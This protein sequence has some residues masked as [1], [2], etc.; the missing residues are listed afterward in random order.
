VSR[1]RDVACHA[2]THSSRL[3]ATSI[4]PINILRIPEITRGNQ[5]DGCFR[6]SDAFELD[7]AVARATF[8]FGCSD[9]IAKRFK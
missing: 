5:K 7:S 4:P 3:K 6:L 9:G 1:D 8:S 2:S